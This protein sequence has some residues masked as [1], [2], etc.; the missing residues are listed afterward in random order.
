[1]DYYNLSGFKRLKR[2]V[3]RNPDTCEITF[4]PVDRRVV[5]SC[6]NHDTNRSIAYIMYAESIESFMNSQ[7]FK[8][9]RRVAR[10]EGMI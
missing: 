2:W 8:K 6:H 3:N 9:F 10:K 7:H 4:N 5:L 1:M